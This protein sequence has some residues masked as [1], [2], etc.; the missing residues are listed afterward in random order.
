MASE[1][2]RIVELDSAQVSPALRALFEASDPASLRSFAVLDGHAA[3]RIFTDRTDN[4]KWGMVQEA[5]FGSL[6]LGGDL[7]AALLHQLTSQLRREGDVLIG[8]WAEDPRWQLLPPDPDYSGFTLE[9]TDRQADA[10][11]QPL[12]EVPAGCELRRLDRTLFKQ[13]TGRSMLIH[14]YGSVDQA[15]EWGYGLC[16]LREDELLCE[17]FAGPAA[18]GIIEVGVETMPHHQKQGYAHITCAHLIQRMEAQGYQTYWNCAKQNI[19]SAALARKLGYR[20]E[21]EYRLLAWN[22]VIPQE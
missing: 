1:K 7:S 12:P 21:K 22:K 4:P 13:I 8:L 3:G 15:L 2:Q 10:G 9:F 16:L 5:A 18:N 11:G 17:T 6:Y 19:A 20:T 14:M